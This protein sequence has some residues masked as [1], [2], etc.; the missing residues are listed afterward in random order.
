MK[1][2]LIVQRHNE[3]KDA[4]GDLAAMVW[5]QVRREP[6]V[7]DALVNQTGE[8]LIADLSVRG[9]WLPQAE[10]L[11]DVRI[12]DTDAQSYLNHTPMAMISTL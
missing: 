9:V 8:T 1:G 6:V 3:I 5:G 4:V 10:A 2:S 12:V 7:S 11:F